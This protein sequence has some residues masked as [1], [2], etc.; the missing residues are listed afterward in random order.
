MT[1]SPGHSF[2]HV[3]LT[4]LHKRG[5]CAES[6]GWGPSCTVSASPVLAS[7]FKDETRRSQSWRME[8]GLADTKQG[9]AETQEGAGASESLPDIVTLSGPAGRGLSGMWRG[10]RGRR[11][12][13]SL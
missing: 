5:Q 13:L 9:C 1:P 8:T 12:K 11:G 6:R 4:A 7:V 3:T 10:C 2:P